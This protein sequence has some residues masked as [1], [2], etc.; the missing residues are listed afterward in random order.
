MHAAVPRSASG[1]EVKLRAMLALRAQWL[2]SACQAFL[3]DRCAKRWSYDT[4][5]G[6]VSWA[7]PLAGSQCQLPCVVENEQR[8]CILARRSCAADLNA[9]MQVRVGAGLQWVPPSGPR[10]LSLCLSLFERY[11]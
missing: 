11:M 5:E 10:R 8:A 6:S 1:E 2:P 3:S 7:G 4:W 9:V